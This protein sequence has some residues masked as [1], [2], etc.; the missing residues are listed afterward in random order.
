M[1]DSQVQKEFEEVKESSLFLFKIFSLKTFAY[2]FVDE[3]L[4]GLWGYFSM[5]M[6]KFRF[7]KLI[8]H[9]NIIH[10]IQ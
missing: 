3:S 8:I 10:K 2:T 9:K 1:L 4:G 6:F 5:R 7:F